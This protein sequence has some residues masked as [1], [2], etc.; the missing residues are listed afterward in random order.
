MG[1]I[2]SKGQDSD[3]PAARQLHDKGQDGDY[4]AARQLHDA[5]LCKAYEDVKLHYTLGRELGRGEFGITYLCTEN[6]TGLE[7]AC[8][9]IPKRKLV[10]DYYK[11][12]VR[13]EVEVMQYLSGQPNIVQFKAAYEDD[14]FVHIVMELC[15]GGEL[16]DRIV[17]RGH[18]SERSAASVFRSNPKVL[19]C[20]LCAGGGA[21]TMGCIFQHKQDSDRPSRHCST[22]GC[23]SCK[24]LMRDAVSPTCHDYWAKNW[25]MNSTGLQFACK[26][27]SKRKLVKDYEKDDVRRE[28]AVMQYLSGQPNIVKF[29]A[30]YEDDQ[31]VLL[32]VMH[33]DLRPENF[34]FTSMDE[35]AVLNANDFGLS[36]F[37][38]EETEQG[39][40]LAILKGEINFQHDPFPSIS[41]SAIELLK[42]KF[43]EMDT[44]NSGTLTYNE[45]KE[46]LAKLGSTLTEFDV[47][48]Y[49]QA[50]DI[51]GNGTIDY[52]EFR[53]AMMQR[54]KLERFE[55]SLQSRPVDELGKAFKDD[56]MGDDATIA[57]IKE[58]M[59]ED[60]RDKD[61]RISY[62]EFRSM[63]KRGTQLHPAVE[64]EQSLFAEM[65]GCLRK[66]L[67]C[68]K[69]AAAPQQQPP[70]VHDA[71]PAAA[72]Q[73]QPIKVHDANPAAAPQQQPLKVHDANPAA[74]PQ[75]QPPKL[76]DAIL[77]KPYED[78]KLHYTIGKELGSG[79]SA[80]IYLC[81]ENSTGLQFACKSISKKKI[82]AAHERDDVRREV[83][84]M[85]H[86][87][88]QPNIVQFKAAYEDDQCVHIVME[89][90]AGGELFDR[91]IARG[92]FS[93]RDAASV[94]RVIMNVANVCHSKGVMH[95]DLKPENF[96]LTS[97]DEN[98]VLKAIDFGLSVFIEEGKEFRDV[99]GSAFYVA[100]EVL[101]RRYGKEADIWSAGVILY[102]LLCGVP[103]F[104]ADTDEGI[105]EEIRKGEIDFQIDPWP[106]ISSSAK[107]LV[108]RMLTQDPKKRVTAAQV[109]EH[110]WLKE[111]GE[112]SDKPIDTAVLFRIKQF[113]AMN[114]LK[115]LALKVIVE[116]LPTEEIQ[117]LKQ[118]FTE[119]DTDKSGTL[120]YDELKAGLAKLG[121]TLREVDVKH[122]ITVDELETAFKEYNMGDDA[123]I[124][125]IMSE[126]DRDK[127]GRISY[128]EFCA[129]MKR[130]TQRRGFASRSLAHVV[131][132][133]HKK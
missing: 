93:E 69:P 110:P 28:V 35:N 85:R 104:W 130:G 29:K 75:Q 71:N 16:F 133:R 129:M 99:C 113:M 118:K 116:N 37:I 68:L 40:A 22:H 11:D 49:M 83:E 65:G 43:T 66:I 17:A 41:S 82:I 50:A 77:G 6:S 33:R 112:A 86:L 15:V 62:D 124:K 47:K 122:Y 101:R 119:M 73:Q 36:V 5:I 74:A 132:M 105:F 87:S 84:I 63:M 23:N 79:S 92:H 57:T 38:E 120:S 25:I 60:D 76:D 70:K 59:S 111:S 121:S 61:G 3:H 44:D 100:P 67:C 109:L 21:Q 91:I 55:I 24:R 89:Y 115:K 7:F 94:F 18:Y 2:F 56:G 103:P 127:D 81:T 19:S 96:L 46:G 128:D 95:R 125:E 32:G 12:D 4:P 102:I 10:N 108:R 20:I 123:T 26:S 42:E 64:L 88:G 48:Q 1:C 9:S 126:V 78:V 80:I 52:I 58:I 39:V 54:H 117:K 31:F 106:V 107:E 8:K 90:C 97:K 72:P 98:A 34:L 27:I 51:D 114:K 53:T 30:A 45:L 13:R 14:Q 131:T